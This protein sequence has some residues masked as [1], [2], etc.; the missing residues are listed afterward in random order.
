MY[1]ILPRSRDQ[2]FSISAGL[3]NYFFNGSR[4]TRGLHANGMQVSLV[5]LFAG[6]LSL[7]TRC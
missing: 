7:S 2:I 5:F 6:G 1:Y 3:I 4:E